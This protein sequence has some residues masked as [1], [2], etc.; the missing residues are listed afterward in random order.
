[1]QFLETIAVDH[2]RKRE[3]NFYR[4]TRPFGSHGSQ[5]VPIEIGDS[6]ER[7]NR[8]PGLSRSQAVFDNKIINEWRSAVTPTPTNFKRQ[9]REIPYVIQIDSPPSNPKTNLARTR[10]LDAADVKKRKFA[11]PVSTIRKPAF[12]PNTAKI[13]AEAKL[14]AVFVHQS[15]TKIE[16]KSEVDIENSLWEAAGRITTAEQEPP[17][18]QLQQIR[19]SIQKEKLKREQDEQRRLEESKRTDEDE[20][21]SVLKYLDDFDKPPENNKASRSPKKSSVHVRVEKR[22]PGTTSGNLFVSDDEGDEFVAR[23]E[24]DNNLPFHQNLAAVT[25][26]KRPDSLAASNPGGKGVTGKRRKWKHGYV[27][28]G[29]EIENLVSEVK[30]A[31]RDIRKEVTDC[32]K[33]V[34]Q[35][36]RQSITK[37]EVTTM[38]KDLKKQSKDRDGLLRDAVKNLGHALSKG[39][40]STS[41]SFERAKSFYN[42]VGTFVNFKEDADAERKEAA[43]VALERAKRAEQTSRTKRRRVTQEV[44]E[45]LKGAGIEDDEKVQA[46]VDAQMEKWEVRSV[47]MT[48]K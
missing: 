34:K 36:I 26:P 45:T 22:K 2:K 3:D 11:D 8:R 40:S 35:H 20:V 28:E 5:A 12:R 7:L 30:V 27:K 23:P 41:S 15:P 18:N 48:S 21:E 17:I 38:V 16:Q 25:K 14:A 47:R 31:I 37:K 43:K 39:S 1:M 29:D 24:E 32:R 44:K 33:E 19:N 13:E 6:P 10:R 9:R 42:Q 4:S 46:A